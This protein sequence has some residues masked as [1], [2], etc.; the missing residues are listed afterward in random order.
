MAVSIKV[1]YSIS[2]LEISGMIVIVNDV[3][4][5]GRTM[6]DIMGRSIVDALNS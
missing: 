1:R 3:D 2:A 6:F 4:D 5:L